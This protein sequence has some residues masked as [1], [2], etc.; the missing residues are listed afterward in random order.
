MF[1]AVVEQGSVRRAAQRV[2]RTAP[3]VS[4]ALRKLE[5]EIGAPLFTR[6]D[7]N[8]QELTASGQLLYSYGK[9]I[10]SLKREAVAGLQAITKCDT[11][12]VR[13]GANESTSL[14]LLPKL[15]HAFQEAHPGLTLETMCDNSE[16]IVGALKNCQIELALVAF[17]G[18]ETS[19][20][21]YL[22][23]RDEIVLIVSPGHRLTKSSRVAIKDLAHEVLI[24][25][26]E[27]SSLHE[28]VAHAFLE[29]GT[30]LNVKVAN[31]TIEG[32]KRMVAEAV[33]VGFVPL[34]CVQEEETRGELATVRVDGIS[35]QREL[36]LLHRQD[37]SLSPGAEAF[38]RVGLRTA[39]AW[40]NSKG[41]QPDRRKDTNCHSKG[42]ERT[43]AYC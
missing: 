20:K 35:R 14:Y 36:W 41:S 39:R 4:I 3:A 7:R 9:R 26:N 38:V 34:L 1:A 18:D 24:A 27:K 30:E 5:E 32:I 28:E 43:R 6:S 16:S 42:I 29:S 8:H 15:M 19:L 40:L 23:M 2:F 13:I 31:V 12:R 11:G 21:K 17:T 33:G 25:E 37:G 10:L 22:I